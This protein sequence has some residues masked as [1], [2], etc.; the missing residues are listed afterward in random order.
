MKKLFILQ[1]RISNDVMNTSAY[2]NSKSQM[3]KYLTLFSF[4][5][6]TTLGFAQSNYQDVV[7]L[8][9]G[10]I[11]RGLIIEQTPNKTIKLETADRNVFIY[12][13]DE[14][15]KLTKEQSNIKSNTMFNSNNKFK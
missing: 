9:N 1:N 7:H 3:K 10:S 8:K 13:M 4:I 12:Q 11:I 15:E 2:V 5:L 6:I 14:I